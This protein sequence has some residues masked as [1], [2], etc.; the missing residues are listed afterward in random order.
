MKHEVDMIKYGSEITPEGL[1]NKNYFSYS[2]RHEYSFIQSR[3]KSYAFIIELV[4]LTKIIICFCQY[5]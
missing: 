5:T 4:C 2:K 3:V 1:P